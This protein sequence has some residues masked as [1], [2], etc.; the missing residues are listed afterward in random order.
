MNT[1]HIHL[2]LNHFPIIGSMIGSL[3]LLWGIIKKQ[4]NV[5][6]IAA[7]IIVVMTLLAIPVFITGEPAEEAVEHLPGV[8][9]SMTHLHEEAAEL[10]I[11]LMGAAGIA[12]LAALFF[13]W[14]KNARTK[15]VFVV[16]LVMSLLAF[17]AM[18][19]TGYYGGKIRHTEI[20][21]AAADA[22]QSNDNENGKQGS[23]KEKEEGNEKDND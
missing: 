3:V 6:A 9:E 1:T 18:A 20:S 7:V 16:A 12:S 8:S 5:K 19:R 4:E 11:W 15:L 13:A 10:A 22:N 2:L 21:A 14:Q 23:D 17:G